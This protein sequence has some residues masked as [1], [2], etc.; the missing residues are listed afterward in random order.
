MR[1]VENCAYF[2]AGWAGLDLERPSGQNGAFFHAQQADTLAEPGPLLPVAHVEPAAVVANAQFRHFA[3][4]RQRH[5][6]VCGPRVAGDVGQ[7]LLRD[8]EDGRRPP[9]IE[10]A[11]LPLPLPPGFPSRKVTAPATRPS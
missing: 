8:S 1:L 5:R 2:G 6:Y 10:P 9:P 3:V 4:G 7:R 11:L